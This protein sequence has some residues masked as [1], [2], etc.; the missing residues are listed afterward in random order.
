VNR[1]VF[2]E[3]AEDD[4]IDIWVRIAPDNE[5]AADRLIDEIHDVT[6]KL[7]TFPLMGRTADQL[8]VGARAFVHRDYLIVY[9]PMDYGIAVL[10]IAH[11]ARDI[12]MLEFPPAP[13]E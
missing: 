5:A 11:G 8:R 4:L 10:R 2:T 12:A 7:V 9:R 1:I 13:E 6:R 3:L